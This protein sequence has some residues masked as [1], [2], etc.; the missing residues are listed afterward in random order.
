MTF[1]GLPWEWWLKTS[2]DQIKD[3]DHY[4]ELM[5]KKEESTYHNQHVFLDFFMKTC[6]YCQHFQD[7]W[8]DLVD[9]IEKKFGKD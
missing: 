8:N 9:I 1:N 5:M 7:S 2:G 3:F 4:K 6:H